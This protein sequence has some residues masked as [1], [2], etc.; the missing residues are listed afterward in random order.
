MAKKSKKAARKPAKTAARPARK[1]A[2]K[3]AA[4]KKAAAKKVA[5]KASPAP[6]ARGSALMSV[7]P[8]ITAND[9]AASTKWYCD[10]LGFTVVQRWENQ[11]GF[12]GAEIRSGSVTIY[13]NQDDWKQ[14]RDRVKGQGTRTFITTGPDIDG[15]AKA[16][17]ARGGTL[18]SEPTDEFGMRAFSIN[19]PDGF[20]LTFMTPLAK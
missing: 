2:P 20:K 7:S 19:D 14:G 3:K 13:I 9:A 10:V 18:A 1:A 4:P 15:Y 16:I 12:T 5:A 8:S 11:G 17:K 6:K